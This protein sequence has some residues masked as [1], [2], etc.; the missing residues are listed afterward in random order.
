MKAQTLEGIMGDAVK[1]VSAKFEV[2]GKRAAY[3]LWICSLVY[4]VNWMDRQ[5][6]SS[7]DFVLFHFLIKTGAVNPQYLG[8]LCPV[9]AGL[10]QGR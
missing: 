7:N 2:G 3:V 5:V 10:L 6:F 9:V 4:M 1:A 8:G